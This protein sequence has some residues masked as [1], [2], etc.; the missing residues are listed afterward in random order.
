MKGHLV[1]QR[2]CVKKLSVGLVPVPPGNEVIH[3]PLGLLTVA[4][5]ASLFPRGV[6]SSR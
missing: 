2:Q 6:R 5:L 1:S 3:R 4:E